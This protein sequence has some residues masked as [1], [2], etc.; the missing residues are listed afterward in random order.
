MKLNKNHFYFLTY[1]ENKQIQ[2]ILFTINESFILERLN[3][4]LQNIKDHLSVVELCSNGGVRVRNVPLKNILSIR[5][6][7]VIKEESR[8]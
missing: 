6:Q 1:L 5:K 8:S 4:T 3:T 7:R 2:K